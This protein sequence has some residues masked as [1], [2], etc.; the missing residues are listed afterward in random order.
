MMLNYL[1]HFRTTRFGMK[2]Q[3]Y[4]VVYAGTTTEARKVAANLAEML[5]GTVEV[6][7]VRVI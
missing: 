1:V 4:H 3:T 7:S 2:Q 5:P 6:V